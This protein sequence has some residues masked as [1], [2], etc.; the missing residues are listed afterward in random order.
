MGRVKPTVLWGTSNFAMVLGL[1][2]WFLIWGS[3][4]HS[5]QA[6]SGATS[7]QESENKAEPTSLSQLVKRWIDA[8]A[9]HAPG[10]ADSPA[11]TIGSWPAADLEPVLAYIHKLA[12]QSTRSLQRTLAR[13]NTRRVLGL[14]DQEAKQGDLNRL[15]KRGVLLHTDIALL[16]LGTG[17]PADSRNLMGRFADGRLLFGFSNSHWQFARDLLE[18]LPLPAQDRLVRHWYS[19]TTA[20]MQS[21]RDLGDS[22]RNLT[23]ALTKFPADA[24]ILFYAGVLH[25]IYASPVSQN[26]SLPPGWEIVYGSEEKELKAAR[27]LLQKAVAIDPNFMEAR[28]RY[29][30]VLGLLGKHQEAAAELQVAAGAIKDPQLLYYASLYFGHELEVLGRPVEAREQFERAAR[31]YPTAQSPLLALSRLANQDGDINSAFSTLQRVFALKVQD[32]WKADPFWN[33]DVAH[34]RDALA[35]VAEMYSMFGGVLQ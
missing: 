4:F 13:G 23:S 21:R 27:K 34:V 26:Y 31:L 3:S 17:A 32:T 1:A 8:S 9:A 29:G 6:L 11:V 2:I 18:L 25:E 22:G 30:R 28:L 5:A 10:K 15:L 19:A 20:Y 35:L 24:R 7:F 33:Y 12:S 14:T 16:E